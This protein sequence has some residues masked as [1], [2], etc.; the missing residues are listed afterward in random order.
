MIIQKHILLAGCLV[1]FSSI[2][3]PALADSWDPVDDTAAGA[4]SLLAP[5]LSNQTHGAHA[6]SSTDTND[7]FKIN[8]TAGITYL[9]EATGFSDTQGFLYSDTNG[10]LVAW[11]EDDGNEG[12]NFLI[13]YT[14]SS[15]GEYYLKVEEWLNG[16]ADYVF[17][18][19][20]AIDTWDP[21]DDTGAGAT[22]R[23]IGDEYEHTEGPHSLTDTDSA[24]WYRFSL[25]AGNTYRFEAAGN[26]DTFGRLFSDSAGTLEVASNDD[27]LDIVIGET[28]F[29]VDYA[30]TVTGDYYLQ[31]VQTNNPIEYANYDFNYRLIEDEW[32]PADD[33]EGG[34]TTLSPIDEIIREHGPH[35][36]NDTDTND[37]FEV[38]LVAGQT[39]RFESI[40]DSD[41]EAYLYS[42]SAGTI[43]EAHSDDF[44]PLVDS[45]FQIFYTP[46]SS[47]TY[48]LKVKH[49]TSGK[50]AIYQLEYGIENDL[51]DDGMSDV[52]EV[53]YFGST[54]AH[55]NAY[56]DSDQFTNIEEYIA[57]TDPTN[58]ASF[59]VVTN[60]ISGGNFVV[61]W[62]SV[63]AREYK[64]LWAESL[65][66]S[67]MPQGLP[68]DH[69][70]NSYTDTA[71][72]AESS[73]F[74][75]VEV[76][77]K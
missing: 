7:W 2:A 9:F 10:T 71:H 6:L 47:G 61:E 41:T 32:D 57:G 55:P 60:G 43:E 51:D 27:S 75:K 11:N 23:S 73:G 37:W 46:L 29:R 64:V 21:G 39:Y 36:L 44:Q 70:Q 65:T 34:A 67:F 48:Y 1:F 40:G 59:F 5:T 24:D 8:L 76:Q 12:A 63:A 54:N 22:I 68:I 72:N 20:I 77:L 74:Y 35:A 45:N 15:F 25:R 4:T 62:P 17:N 33:S 30:S 16:D 28:S 18:Y 13:I 66:N 52:W 69:P 50:S 42:D 14:P 31:V 38:V 58:T 56:G 53:A 49:S 19:R 3:N 26:W